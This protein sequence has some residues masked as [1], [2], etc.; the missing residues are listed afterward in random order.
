MVGNLPYTGKHGLDVPCD[1]PSDVSGAQSKDPIDT[2][3][4][5]APQTGNVTAAASAAPAGAITGLVQLQTQI[6]CM[7]DQ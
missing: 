2:K 7:W 5:A 6:G 1:R 3:G 4:C